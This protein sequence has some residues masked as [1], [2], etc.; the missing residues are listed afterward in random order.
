LSRKRTV[1]ITSS[2]SII[3]CKTI[4]YKQKGWSD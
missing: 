2:L 4:T 1:I 3:N